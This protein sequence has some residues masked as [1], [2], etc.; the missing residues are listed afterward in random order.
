MVMAITAHNSE[1][2]EEILENVWASFITGDALRSCSSHDDP[3]ST[4]TTSK[5]EEGQVAL[6][7]RLP[8]LG[9]WISMGAE[10]WNEL[11]D[12]IMLSNSHKNFSPTTSIDHTRSSSETRTPTAIKVASRHYRGVRRRPWG[13]YAAEIR[14]ASRKGARVWLGTF[15]TAEEAALA[16]DKAALRMRGPHAQLNFPTKRET[17]GIESDPS[18]GSLLDCTEINCNSKKLG[19]RTRETDEE[20]HTELSARK[21]SNYVQDIVGNE[22]EIVELEDLGITY[23]ESLLSS[24]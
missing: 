5:G 13:K 20:I 1:A 18:V 3:I 21:R 19:M 17:E 2:R 12:G 4:T 10:A 15:E 6:L 8:S 7:Q 24:S 11:L 16:Y 22:K 23:L 9:R 14:D